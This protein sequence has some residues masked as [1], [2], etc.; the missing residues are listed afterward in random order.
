MNIS[1]QNTRLGSMCRKLL[2]NTCSKTFKPRL[3]VNCKNNQMAWP[4]ALV[5]SIIMSLWLLVVTQV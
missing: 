5:T 2:H 1:L 4:L 3:Q